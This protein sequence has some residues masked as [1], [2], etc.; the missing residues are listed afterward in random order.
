MDDIGRN[1]MSAWRI[2]RVAAGLGAAI[3]VLTLLPPPAVADHSLGRNCYFCHKLSSTTVWGGTK[4]I[5][6]SRA[7]GQPDYTYS[8]YCDFC[9]TGIAEEFVGPSG[10]AGN[11][12]NHPVYIIS[13]TGYDIHGKDTGDGSYTL[14]SAGSYGDVKLR[15]KD[16]HGGDTANGPLGD[17][18]PDLAPEHYT[19]TSGNTA[20]DGYPD[21][22]L[23]AL[24][25]DDALSAF[26]PVWDGSNSGDD[27]HAALN[28]QH[29][30]ATSALDAEAAYALCFSCHDGSTATSHGVDVKSAYT[31]GSGHFFKAT[32]DRIGCVDCHDSHGSPSIKLYNR[33]GVITT[34]DGRAICLD[35]HGTTKTFTDTSEGTSVTSFAVLA[36]P[37]PGSGGLGENVD[38]HLGAGS[39]PCTGCHDPHNPRSARD[40]CYA[41]HS[42]SG[43]LVA[44]LGGGAIIVD[45]S[46]G[47]SF[48]WPLGTDGRHDI[49]FSAGAAGSA[50]CLDCH[51]ITYGQH[52][53][54][55]TANDLKY[56]GPNGADWPITGSITETGVD[57]ASS[58]EFCLGC[59]RGGASYW[60][61]APPTV[62]TFIDFGLD[63]TGAPPNADGET[64]NY[65]H[66]D[67]TAGDYSG[68]NP[69][70]YDT[71][72]TPASANPPSGYTGVPMFAH[73][74]LGNTGAG[75]E[76]WQLGAAGAPQPFPCLDCHYAHGSPNDVLY[77][78]P[79]GSAGVGAEKYGTDRDM[80][81][82]CHD[83]SPPGLEGRTV[84]DPTAG[85]TP[86]R[87]GDTVPPHDP[88]STVRCSPDDTGGCHNPHAPS[89][90]ICHG[91][92][93]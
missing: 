82:D 84:P 29:R 64:N 34:D 23:T 90:E 79:G 26:S 39:E 16:C 36:A 10:A 45:G 80:C 3:L 31:V 48:G 5:D 20:T 62:D 60:G 51:A 8:L 32:G 12:T 59:H 83:G 89:C 33:P 93:P 7:I 54:G 74:T 68:Q 6:T 35:C 42:Q 52:A 38:A 85:P 46:S 27:P 91:Y 24:A 25:F 57:F 73:F 40:D 17:L 53:D 4:A 50:D 30:A 49:S 19:D 41:C 13:G 15:C 55:D 88:G 14:Q 69:V 28:Y 87:Y 66:G 92:P 22:D 70:F 61:S 77:R 67:D 78:S 58:I 56:N 18:I 65:G 86:D 81:L 47:D 76:W 72:D 21:H 44:G 2:L 75:T 63:G 37:T 43:S 71:A 1:D 9:H 11:A